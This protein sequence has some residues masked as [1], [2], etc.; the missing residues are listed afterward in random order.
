MFFKSLNTL[1]IKNPLTNLLEIKYFNQNYVNCILLNNNIILNIKLDLTNI[2]SNNYQIVIS[3]P[4]FINF[5]LTNFN[6]QI[7]NFYIISNNNLYIYN[8]ISNNNLK[9]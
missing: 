2:I 1:S 9:F 5:I 3:N 4:I 6:I 7:I 8:Y